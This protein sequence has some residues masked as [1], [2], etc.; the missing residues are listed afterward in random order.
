MQFTG[1]RWREIGFEGENEAEV[2]KHAPVCGPEEF[3]PLREGG[4]GAVLWGKGSC[5]RNIQL[6][7]I[8]ELLKGPKR[9]EG[10]WA[11][12]SQGSCLK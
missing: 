8:R 6:E 7:D 3:T 12:F 5:G 11:F 2:L 9:R 10:N 4:R 1:D